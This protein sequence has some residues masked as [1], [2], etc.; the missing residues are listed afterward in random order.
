NIPKSNGALDSIFNHILIQKRYNA[1][2][3][4]CGCSNALGG[5]LDWPIPRQT[6]AINTHNV[7]IVTLRRCQSNIRDITD[8]ILGNSGYIL[9][10]RLSETAG[11]SVSIQS[12]ATAQSSSGRG[13]VFDRR[14]VIPTYFGDIR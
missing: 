7:R 13:Q 12:D 1:C 5:Y 3:G 10:A 14:S 8:T 9:P 6:V 2:K 4:G 11:A